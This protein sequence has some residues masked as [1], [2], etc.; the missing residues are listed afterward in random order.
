[1]D[2]VLKT[3][4]TLTSSTIKARNIAYTITFGSSGTHT[5][6]VV[7]ARGRVDV[8]AFVVLR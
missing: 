2:G 6:R 7:V 8:E 5:I 3:T 4:L 1:M